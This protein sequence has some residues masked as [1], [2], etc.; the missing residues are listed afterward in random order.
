MARA[1]LVLALLGGV[2]IV[3][4]T[5]TSAFPPNGIGDLDRVS[6]SNANA[7]LTKGATQPAISGNGRYVAFTTAEDSATSK[8]T[9]GA[10]DVYVRDTIAGTTT[11]ISK[12]ENTT[13]G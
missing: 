1:A 7:Q 9:N 4:A 6:V 13:N 2:S 12:F 5:R 8:D 3:A 10:N 11:L